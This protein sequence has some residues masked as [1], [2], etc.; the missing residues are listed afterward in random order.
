M[1][2]RIFNLEF[3]QSH[4]QRQELISVTNNGQE[5]CKHNKTAIIISFSNSTRFVPTTDTV[6]CFEVFKIF[7][8]T[9]INNY[10]ITGGKPEVPWTVAV[11]G[12]TGEK[13]R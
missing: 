3:D 5:T 7:C 1:M 11:D 4:G 9:K 8:Q 12:A 6:F 2:I 10:I 13:P